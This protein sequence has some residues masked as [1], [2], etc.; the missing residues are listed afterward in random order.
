MLVGM[1]CFQA[2][3]VVAGVSLVLF[4][5]RA[6]HNCIHCILLRMFPFDACLRRLYKMQF[7]R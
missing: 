7:F 6:M 4:R 2:A 5:R 1:F 3:V